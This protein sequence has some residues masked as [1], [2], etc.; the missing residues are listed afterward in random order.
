MNKIKLSS[1]LASILLV[2]AFFIGWQTLLT[3]VV[4]MLAFVEITDGMKQTMV[5]ILSFFVGL[6]VV[7]MGWNLIVNGVDV[8]MSSLDKLI[9]IINGYLDSPMD[10]SKLYLYLLDPIAK[11]VELADGIVSWLFTFA[12]FGFIVTL[13]TNKAMKETFISRKINEFINKTLYWVNSLDGNVPAQPAAPQ[14][15]VAQ[16]QNP[17]MPQ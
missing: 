1:G 6:T 17:N 2:V 13:L 5:R 4:L 3:L 12:K 10:I 16:P 7:T 15:P 14:A 11:V 8:I 9:A